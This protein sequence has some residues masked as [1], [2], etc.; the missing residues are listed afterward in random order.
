MKEENEQYAIHL[1]RQSKE[2]TYSIVSQRVAHA[3]PKERKKEFYLLR[4]CG[5]EFAKEEFVE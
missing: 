5:E 4:P 1:E 2:C 3:E